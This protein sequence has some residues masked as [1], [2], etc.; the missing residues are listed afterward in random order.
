MQETARQDGQP[1]VGDRAQRIGEV[2][3][4]IRHNRPAHPI[5]VIGDAVIAA[6][7]VVDLPAGRHHERVLDL[8]VRHHCAQLLFADVRAR[9]EHHNPGGQQTGQDR[10]RHAGPTGPGSGGTADDRD[11]QDRA[12][13][14]LQGD[15]LVDEGQKGQKRTEAGAQD[16]CRAVASAPGDQEREGDQRRRPVQLRPWTEEG[17]RHG[18]REHRD[19]ESDHQP[20]LGP[21]SREQDPVGE[22]RQ[23]GTVGNNRTPGQG[24]DDGEILLLWECVGD[25]T[26]QAAPHES[27]AVIG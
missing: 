11:R 5:V 12:E 25:L 19:E 6:Q 27:G 22:E 7:Q 23:P 1:L 14:E 13:S 21:K 3:A 10:Q 20:T 2:A 9:G 17:E 4:E 24:V 8:S 15:G 18:E 26:G 16:E